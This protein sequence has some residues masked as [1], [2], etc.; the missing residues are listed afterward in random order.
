[1]KT[2][3]EVKRDQVRRRLRATRH[4]RPLSDRVL[5]PLNCQIRALRRAHGLT[6]TDVAR[7]IELSVP[8]LSFIER[9]RPPTLATARKLC[10]FFEESVERL[11]PEAV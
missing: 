6:M 3:E 10:V 11:W 4:G 1:M 2:L 8:A 7:A 9:G 5:G